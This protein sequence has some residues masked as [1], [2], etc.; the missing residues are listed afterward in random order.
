VPFP[1]GNDASVFLKRQERTMLAMSVVHLLFGLLVAGLF[2]LVN[3]WLPGYH[4]DTAAIA[5]TTLTILFFAYLV[6]V[7]NRKM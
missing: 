1:K 3:R 7:N 5:T 4:F 6:L 2:Y